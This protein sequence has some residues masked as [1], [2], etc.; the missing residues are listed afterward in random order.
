[1]ESNLFTFDDRL[2]YPLSDYWKNIVRCRMSAP[3]HHLIRIL[4]EYIQPSFMEFNYRHPRLVHS[5]GRKA[6]LDIWI[7]TMNI[8]I[9]YQGEHHYHQVHSIFHSNIQPP[10]IISHDIIG[11]IELTIIDCMIVMGEVSESFY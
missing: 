4:S 2:A 5:S 1:M 3:Q 6:E 11:L 7:P 8:A 9:E 10:S